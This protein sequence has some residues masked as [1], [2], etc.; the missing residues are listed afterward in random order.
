MKKRIYFIK[1]TACFVILS[2]LVFAKAFCDDDDSLVDILYVRDCSPNYYR[3][4]ENGISPSIFYQSALRL[5]SSS[6]IMFLAQKEKSPPS[7]NIR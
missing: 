7:L 4:T 2:L 5:S 3:L 6:I 1:I